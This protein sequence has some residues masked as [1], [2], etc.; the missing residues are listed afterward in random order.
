MRTSWG[1]RITLLA[2]CL[3]LGP[4]VLR[5]KEPH[6][7]DRAAALDNAILADDIVTAWSLAEALVDAPEPW[8]GRGLAALTRLSEDL[9]RCSE[10]GRLPALERLLDREDADAWL[11]WV[12]WDLLRTNLERCRGWDALDTL[13]A[14]PRELGGWQLDAAPGTSGI[15]DAFFRIRAWSPAP[16]RPLEDVVRWTQRTAGRIFAATTLCLDE[17]SRVAV[18]LDSR[19]PGSL[20]IDDHLVLL[21]EPGT[22]TLLTGPLA[23]GDVLLAPGCH[24][25]RLGLATPPGWGRAR[26]RYFVDPI[27]ADTG[28]TT[29]AKPPGPS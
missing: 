7:A 17:P 6:P 29:A 27:G 13:E 21:A 1:T 28:R 15:E 14:R 24:K 10:G 12:A 3:L 5:A 8:S 9:S 19:A 2:L 20:W 22:E 25:V 16:N 26:V 4:P 18:R 11:R 23:A